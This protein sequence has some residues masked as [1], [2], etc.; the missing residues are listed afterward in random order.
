MFWSCEK[1]IES[2]I[3]E[4]KDECMYKIRIHQNRDDETSLLFVLSQ[5]SVYLLLQGPYTVHLIW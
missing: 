3:W 4:P 5:K 1:G 2:K